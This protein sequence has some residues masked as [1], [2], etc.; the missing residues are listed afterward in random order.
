MSEEQERL[1]KIEERYNILVNLLKRN[2][3]KSGDYLMIRNDSV[4]IEFLQ[5]V[6]D[7]EF[8]ALMEKTKETTDYPF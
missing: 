5:T 4:I 7:I 2:I 1:I 8:D 6:E 3:K